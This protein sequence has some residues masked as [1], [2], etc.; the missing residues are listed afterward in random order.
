MTLLLAQILFSAFFTKF[1]SLVLP[2]KNTILGLTLIGQLEISFPKTSNVQRIKE[3]INFLSLFQVL[4]AL[5]VVLAVMG[6]NMGCID[7]LAN[8]K[9]IQIYGEAVAPFLQVKFMTLTHTL[10]ILVSANI[11]ASPAGV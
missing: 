10:A 2:L 1:H 4:G 7:C 6:F 3:L 9:M 8:L 11:G 5:G